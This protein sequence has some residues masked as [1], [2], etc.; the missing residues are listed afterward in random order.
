VRLVHACVTREADLAEHEVFI[1]S[2][3][4]TVVHREL[5]SIVRQACGG[6]RSP[7]FVSPAVARLGLNAKRVLGVLSGNAPFERPWMLEFLDRPWVVDTNT[8]CARLQWACT[9]ALRVCERL[10]TILDHLLREP[11]EWERRNRLRG[12]S[13]LDYLSR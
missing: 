3:H 12:S 6:G 11:R 13:R 8:T 4:G 10:P 9:P 1:A 5:F 2:Q 7:L